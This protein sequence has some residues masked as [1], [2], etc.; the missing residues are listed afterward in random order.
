MKPITQTKYGTDGYKISM[1]NIFWFMNMVQRRQIQGRYMFVD[2]N[3]TQYPK[4]HADLLKEE[5]GH[6]STLSPNSNIADY[7]MEKW[8]FINQEFIRWYNQVFFHDP[9]QIDLSQKDGDLRLFVEGPLHT[10]THWEI[11]LLRANSVLLTHEL[12]REPKPGWQT[13]AYDNARF[14][15]ENDVS[16]SE[17]GGRRPFSVEVHEG[18]LREY[19]KFRKAEGKGGLLGTSWIEYAY[20][21]NLMVMGTMAHEYVELMAALFDYK[22][23]N[24]MAMETWIEHYG[25]RLG[26]YLPDTFTTEVALRD[27]DQY[28]AGV[29]EGTRQDSRNPYWYANLMMKHYRRISIDAREKSIVYSNSLKTRQ[30][31]YDVTHYLP[32]DFKRAALLGGFIT[33]N[34]GY[35]PYN[36]VLKLVAVKI[37]NGSWIDVVKLSDDPAKS[38]GKP[39]EIAK[40]RRALRLK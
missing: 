17:G 6:I 25:K 27:F 19:A 9:N 5:I 13:E 22:N 28:F 7:V 1:G 30:E 10:A 12:G 33:N 35:D 4:G 16:N 24:R 34:V 18:A 38:I 3:H 36:T 14:F 32:G 26:Y 39:E 40:C 11:P 21:Q 8:P 31:I 37:A 23:A 20:D 2:R 15:A 29:F